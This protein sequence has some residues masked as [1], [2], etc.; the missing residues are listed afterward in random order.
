MMEADSDVEPTPAAGSAL[1]ASLR[2]GLHLV[3]TLLWVSIVLTV[4]LH[5][6]REPRPWT[7]GEALG[8]QG[9]FLFAALYAVAALTQYPGRR[10]AWGGVLAVC[11]ALT[12]LA[13][14]A[15][16]QRDPIP[17]L[18]TVVMAQLAYRWPMRRAVAFL[19]ITNIALYAIYLGFL[20]PGKALAPLLLYVTMQVFSLMLIGAQIRSE[21]DRA[22]LAESNGALRAMQA[23]LEETVRDRERLRMARDLHDVMGHKLTALRI[24]VQVLQQHH[25]TLQHVPE[26]ERVAQLS[27]EL[28]AD[29]RAI[30]RQSDGAAGIALQEALR[31]IAHSYP[32]ATVDVAVDEA[33][34]VR[35]GEVAQLLLRVAQ[36][37]TTNAF[38]HGGAGHVQ[39]ELRGLGTS[40]RIRVIDDGAGL[41]GSPA[42]FGLGQLRE[43][44]EARGG[45]LGIVSLPGRGVE[46][47]AELRDGDTA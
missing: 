9:L 5:V 20:P 8:F 15:L 44:I 43:R 16:L 24:N 4:A 25:A 10:R 36:E 33:L 35:D 39:I 22:A 14:F 12:V 26:L 11:E 34:R 18:L 13:A 6:Q 19:V 38:R 3:T 40:C 30:V 27:R 32:T 7:N 46:L 17:A 2:R 1:P 28:L 23:L 42:G 21:R 31:G 45:R 29:T 41:R 37:G 47:T